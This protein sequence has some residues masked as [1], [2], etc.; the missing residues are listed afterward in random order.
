MSSVI[1]DL[2]EQFAIPV[3]RHTDGATLKN[4]ALALSRGGMKVLEITL[5]SEAA[6]DVIRDLSQEHDLVIGAGT[7]LN[8]AQAQKAIDA[9]AKFLV[10]PGLD[11]DAV[12]YAMK[13]NIPFIPGVLTPTE[14][15]RASALGCTLVKLFPIAALRGTAY[16]KMLKAPF[17]QMQWMCTGG[18]GPEDI[19]EYR[20]A[21]AS[22]VGL[23][24]QLTP[25]S[26]IKQGQWEEI[27]RLAQTCLVE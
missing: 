9:G 2:K 19:S 27:S 11:E 4:I 3:I 12:T 7:I 24:G 1:E 23:G 8:V 13:R 14:V 17:P 26:A 20:H 5:M 25:D 15:M 16:V 6:Y 21:G 22:C 10:S 18:I